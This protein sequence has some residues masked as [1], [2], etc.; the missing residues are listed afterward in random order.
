MMADIEAE[1]LVVRT[2][3]VEKPLSNTNIKSCV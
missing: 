2:S 1:T 3:Y